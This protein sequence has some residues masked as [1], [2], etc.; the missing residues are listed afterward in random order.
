MGSTADRSAAAARRTGLLDR[1]A[2]LTRR[3][4]ASAVGRESTDDRERRIEALEERVDHLEALLEGLQDAI[5]RESV[6]QG[7]RIEALETGSEPGELSRA[8]SRDAR[9]RGIS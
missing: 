9:E 1:V 7:G 2:L 8:I 6:R 5:H 3:K 4:R